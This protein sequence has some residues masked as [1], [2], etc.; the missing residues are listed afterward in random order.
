[1][2]NNMKSFTKNKFS[3]IVLILLVFVR[4]APSKQDKVDDTNLLAEQE[5]ANAP[6]DS[7]QLFEAVAEAAREANPPR[8]LSEEEKLENKKFEKWIGNYKVNFVEAQ[9]EGPYNVF[10]EISLKNQDLVHFTTYI[11]AI[12]STEKENLTVMYGTVQ[13]SNKNN[14]EIKYLPEVL[15][16]GDRPDWEDGFTLYEE[17]GAFYVKSDLFVPEEFPNG[18]IPIT[19]IKIKN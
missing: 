9:G 2:K 13:M 10:I 14:T 19:K 18:K 15:F 12:N 17:N 11:K 7:A 6:I 3:I 5:K 4:C 8:I 16:D 1:M